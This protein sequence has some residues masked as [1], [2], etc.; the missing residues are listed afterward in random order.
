MISKIF[1]QFFSL[2]WKIKK[3]DLFALFYRLQEQEQALNLSIKEATAK[4]S[5]CL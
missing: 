4:V 5:L 2:D 1:F 3:C